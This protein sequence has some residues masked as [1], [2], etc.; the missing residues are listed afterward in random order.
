MAADAAEGVPV[1]LPTPAKQESCLLVLA[2]ASRDEAAGCPATSIAAVNTGKS[3]LSSL[4]DN[5]S[6]WWD[7]LQ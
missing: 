5:L 4:E 2:K 3:N 1:A 6:I 7:P